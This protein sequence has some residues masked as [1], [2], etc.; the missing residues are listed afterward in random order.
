MNVPTTTTYTQARIFLDGV[1]IKFLCK[2]IRRLSCCPKFMFRV[3]LE[4]ILISFK[5]NAIKR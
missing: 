2:C 1:Q 3:K 4:L 5:R